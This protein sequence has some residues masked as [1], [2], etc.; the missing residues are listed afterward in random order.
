MLLLTATTF[1]AAGGIHYQTPML[2][3]MAAEF[4]ADSSTIGWVPTLTFGGFL[5]GI[6]LLVPLGDRVD[7]RR[8]II[9][10]HFAAMLALLA[11]G[12]A[13]GVAAAAA[14]GFLI[15]LC[16]C[17][18]QNIVPM[19]AELAPPGERGR[20][21]GTVLTALFLGILFARITGGIVAAQLGWRWMYVL[22]A[23]LLALIAPALIARL[24]HSAP[25]TTLAYPELLASMLAL[26][27]V[28]ADMRRVVAIQ[29]LLG[30]CYGGFWATI[31]TM[32]LQRHGLGPTVAGLIGIPG[33]AG[34][35]IARPAG[36]WL[37]LRGPAPIVTTGIALIIAAYG[38]FAFGVWWPAALAV[39]AALLDSGLRAAMVANQT[40][41][42]SLAP[43][44][45]SRSNTVFGLSVWS[46][47]A[48]GAFIATS[49]LAASG[50]LAVC[51][52]SA[53]AATLAL[54]V[55]LRAM[56]NPGQSPI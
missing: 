7:K 13:Q 11:A 30:I 16:A 36:R 34:I 6:V 56:R 31:A 23:A 52:I 54:G 35:L 12:A 39:G 19:V 33:A 28:H 3:A 44:A 20:A 9:T 22:G 1:A 4:G 8:L 24:P 55:Q 47:N 37:D 21:V 40:V 50:W 2:G 41:V 53:L 42:N 5:V 25:K 15:G 48:V 10:Q 14:S 29:L 32:L 51:A 26:A 18:A 27:R 46:G 49:A 17:Y 43:E 38:V 45:R